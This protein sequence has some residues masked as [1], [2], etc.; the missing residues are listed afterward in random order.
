MS[1]IVKFWGTRGSLPVPGASTQ[2]YGGNTPCV[3]IRTDKA[4]F[5]CDAGSGIRLLND[6]LAKRKHTAPVHLFI[7][8]LHPAH[9]QGLTFFDPLF[10]FNS[11][12][13][14]HCHPSDITS[15]KHAITDNPM[16][17]RRAG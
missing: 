4:I 3:E 5:I 7:S 12:A 2:I 15:F 6:D 14:V 17:M 9:I 13:T 10:A 8:H 11:P 1:M 16:F